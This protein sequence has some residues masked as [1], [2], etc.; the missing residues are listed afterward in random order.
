MFSVFGKKSTCASIINYK[1][2]VT[3]LKSFFVVSFESL[4]YERLK[5]IFG[6]NIVLNLFILAK[7]NYSICFLVMDV[8]FQ[9]STQL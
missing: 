6:Y 7:I 5:L 8:N 3:R 9:L 2:T 1:V 4:W